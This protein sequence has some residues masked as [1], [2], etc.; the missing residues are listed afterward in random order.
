MRRCHYECHVSAYSHRSACKPSGLF[1]MAKLPSKVHGHSPFWLILIRASGKGNTKRVD[2]MERGHFVKTTP[3]QTQ[4]ILRC[5]FG[6][7]IAALRRFP[8]Q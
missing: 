8:T 5:H 7:K 1:V 3:Y 4:T 6:L 2:V